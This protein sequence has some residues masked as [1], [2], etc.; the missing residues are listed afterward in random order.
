MKSIIHILFFLG[1]I[2]G[3]K[4]QITTS[5]I[6]ANFG[7]DADLEANYFNKNIQ[8]GNDDWFNNSPPAY[9]G[10]GVIDTTGAAA[11]I[12]RYAADPAFRQL[13]FYRTM[14]VPAYSIVNNRMWI[15]AVFT[16]D[17]HGS[18]STIFASGANKNGMSP[19]DWSCPVAQSVPD[20]NEILDMM[21]HVRRAGPN[22]TDSLWMFGGLSIENTNGDRYFDF[23]MYQTDI[24][25]DRPSLKFYGYGPDAGHTS[26][27]FD[28]SGNITTPGDII[29]SA[30]Y[31]SSTLTSIEARIWIDKSALLTTPTAFSWNGTFDGAS[32][33]SQF[34]YAGIIP[35]SS[36]F[37]YTGMENNKNTWAGAFNLIRGDNQVVTDYTSGQF[38]EFGVNLTKLGLD[39]VTLLGGN[40]CGMPFRRV[41]VKSRASTSFTAALKD[42]VGPFDF[43]LAPRVMIDADTT[44]LCGLIGISQINVTNPASTSSYTWSTADGH[45]D[46]YNS[47]T[48]ITVD[49]PGTYIVTQRL[50]SGCPI[51][52]TDTVLI[53]T[54]PF[55]F[56]L[57]NPIS[58]FGGRLSYNQVLL[59][60]SA[61]SNKEINYFEIERSTDGSEFTPVNIIRKH[62]APGDIAAYNS[63]DNVNVF[64]RSFIYYRL[65]TIGYNGQVAYSKVVKLFVSEEGKEMIS[66]TPN[67][68]R[69]V[70]RLNI[71][72]SA[73]ENMKLYIYDL[74]GRQMMSSLAR[75]QK[76]NVVIEVKDFQSWPRGI[77]S[78][79]AL[80]GNSVF[81]KKMVLTK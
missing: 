17:Y 12:A 37:F 23:E 8:N 76:G 33:G 2:N 70:M 57:Q 61:T 47:S 60:W 65:K 42:F 10:R 58:D 69:D 66:I 27:K 4:A 39:P 38:M 15:D 78:V 34:G 49:S 11:I 80:L 19:Q 18:D 29:F 45:I 64:N 1:F 14:S 25:Y 21:V 26:W 7:V 52:A 28:A 20:K 74:A 59:N 5:I 36:G 22:I 67:P 35:K 32:S 44:A 3:V 9:T 73:D 43:F 51:Y 46:K 40:D 55:C 56:I 72:S 71:S 79:K 53:T 75:V 31:G 77:Y 48:S 63:T 62:S 30:H 41:L 68:V 16:R 6:K 50:Q 81:T 24:Y 54:N 13:P